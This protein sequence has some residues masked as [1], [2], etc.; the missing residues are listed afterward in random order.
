LGQQ[1]LTELRH[2]LPPYVVSA[3]LRR[4]FH[5]CAHVVEAL[6]ELKK[7]LRQSNRDTIHHFPT[8]SERSKYTYYR[9][10]ND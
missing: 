2:I 1:Q 4:A 6:G 7:V 8:K 5:P 3:P 10:L 9:L